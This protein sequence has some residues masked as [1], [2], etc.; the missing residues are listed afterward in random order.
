MGKIKT[1]W[2]VMDLMKRLDNHAEKMREILSK[3]EESEHPKAVEILEDLR[4]NGFET[5]ACAVNVEVSNLPTYE[6]EYDNEYGCA[7]GAKY[8]GK[9]TE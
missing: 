8:V 4:G 5:L 7:L 2:D 6:L 1:D 9:K 3:L